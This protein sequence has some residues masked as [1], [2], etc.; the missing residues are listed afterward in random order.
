LQENTVSVGLVEWIAAED[1]LALDP[2][3]A[4]GP[5]FSNPASDLRI[6][7]L[8]CP[9]FVRQCLPSCLSYVL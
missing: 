8:S 9:G 4:A 3:V 6:G 1:L 5:D 2:L 7:R